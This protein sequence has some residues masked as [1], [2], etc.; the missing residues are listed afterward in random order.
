MAA[1]VVVTARRLTSLRPLD[2]WNL[3]V[4]ASAPE[5]LGLSL[6]NTPA[7]QYASHKT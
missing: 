3:L 4:L 6:C 2:N 5:T 7:N 1:A